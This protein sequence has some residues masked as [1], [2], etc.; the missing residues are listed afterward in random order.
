MTSNISLLDGNIF[1]SKSQVIVNTVNC[2]GVM[3][4][5]IAL[6][7][8]LRYPVMYSKYLEYCR[9]GELDIGKLW[10]YKSTDRWILNFPT[11]KYWRQPSKVEY[12]HAGLEK[13][14][15]MYQAKGIESIAFPVLGSQHGG[16]DSA[17][18]IKIMISYFSKCSI[19]I[20]IYKYN[21]SAR[22]DLYEIFKEKFQSSDSS[23]IVLKAGLSVK[24]VE[25]IRRALE[26]PAMCQLNQLAVVNGIGAKT[27][28]RAF[29]F[30]VS[31]DM[32]GG[33]FLQAKLNI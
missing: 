5:G 14:T 7:C 22:D 27:L 24:S 1:T 2:E 4:A 3:G 15:T 26:N 11:K 20:E 19:P 18:V 29:C 23:Q 21:N 32:S 25:I 8:R 13:F 6:E 31:G 33:N 17:M 9:N 16:L 10:I 28:E 12:L 30:A